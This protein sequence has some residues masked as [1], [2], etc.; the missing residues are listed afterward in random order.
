MV[1][2]RIDV[3][4]TKW[5]FFTIGAFGVQR[6][7]KSLIKV[8]FVW[9]CKN[10]CDFYISITSSNKAINWNKWAP[11]FMYH[12][13]VCVCVCEIFQCSILQRKDGRNYSQNEKGTYPYD[14]PGVKGPAF[15]S[16]MIIARP[17][18]F[19]KLLASFLRFIQILLFPTSIFFQKILWKKNILK[20][21]CFYC[22]VIRADR[23]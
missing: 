23:L 17:P 19:G 16:P 11:S 8:V 10:K 21:F 15:R 9:I 6:R 20:L 13:I 4:Y 22:L 5:I 3:I 7:Q 18:L 12:V 2:D 1:D 14:I